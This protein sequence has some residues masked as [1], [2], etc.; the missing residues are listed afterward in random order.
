MDKGLVECTGPDARLDCQ[1]THSL[2]C[3]CYAYSRWPWFCDCDMSSCSWT[4]IHWIVNLWDTRYLRRIRLNTMS[5]DKE[6]R[7]TV[8]AL[9]SSDGFLGVL[10][11][12]RLNHSLNGLAKAYS[13][14]VTAA[15]ILQA[16]AKHLF[17][18]ARGY[19]LILDWVANFFNQ[20]LLLLWS[21]QTR[22]DKH[23]VCFGSIC[24]QMFTLNTQTLASFR[25]FWRCVIDTVLVKV[26]AQST[27]SVEVFTL[28]LDNGR[29]I[30]V[31]N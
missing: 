20:F 1:C 13:A 8:V 18:W 11:I 28:H 22:M 29:S 9:H 30:V 4:N 3:T 16:K 31:P 15:S 12:A 27:S 10:C 2:A 25:W 21:T 26:T 24:F 19:N 5:T 17:R 23:H 14:S 6:L 7:L